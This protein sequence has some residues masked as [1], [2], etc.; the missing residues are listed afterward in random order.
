LSNKD[1]ATVDNDRT[2]Q[3]TQRKPTSSPTEG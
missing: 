1:E 2:N 3:D